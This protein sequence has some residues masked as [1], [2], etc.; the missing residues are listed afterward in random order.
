MSV[1]A[2]T[3]P[4]VGVRTT[5]SPPVVRLL[6]ALS[7]A[8][9]VTTVVC[10]VPTVAL[11]AEITDWLAVTAPALRVIVDEVTLDAPDALKVKV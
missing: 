5:V 10:S 1:I 9:T 4:A 2:P 6:P 11:A 7:L 3:D 8:C